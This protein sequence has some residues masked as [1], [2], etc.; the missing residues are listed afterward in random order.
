M[1][2][3]VNLLVQDNT[4]GKISSLGLSQLWTHLTNCLPGISIWISHRH[5]QLSMAKMQLLIVPY[6]HLL[7]LQ[8]SPSEETMLPS[9]SSS[10][11]GQNPCSHPW[12]LSLVS[13]STPCQHNLQNIFKIQPLLTT[14][15]IVQSSHFSPEISHSFRKWSPCSS[16]FTL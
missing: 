12:L 15:T 16:T 2:I 10:C 11:S 13:H 6:P 14:F 8:W 4:A 1:L 3:E 7:L 9:N 5:L